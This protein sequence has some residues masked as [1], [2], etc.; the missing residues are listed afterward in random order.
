M[1]QIGEKG[2]N[3][4]DLSKLIGPTKHYPGSS[5]SYNASGI[6]T[7]VD[8]AGVSRAAK[9]IMTT[10]GAT[11]GTLMVHLIHDYDSSNAKVYCPLPLGTND[12]KAA[13]F[14][15]IKQTGTTIDLSEII[16]AMD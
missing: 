16:V 3:I 4:R 12:I 10:S 11:G 2:F 5:I 8:N 7:V 1:P 15:E 9:G 13:I 6:W 14:D